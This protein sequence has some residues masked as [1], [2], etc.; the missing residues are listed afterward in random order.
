VELCFQTAGLWEAGRQDRMALPMGVKRIRWNTEPLPAPGDGTQFCVARESGEAG[1]GVYDC[2]IVNSDGQV[3]LALD[4]Y[5]T[6]ALPAPLPEQVN[7]PLRDVF[8]G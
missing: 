7:G 3:V 6:V 1:D 2:V 5:L 4:G 8:A